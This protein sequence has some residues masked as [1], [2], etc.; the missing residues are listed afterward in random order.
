MTSISSRRRSRPAP[1]P[2]NRLLSVAG[3]AAAAIALSLPEAPL[4]AA[5]GGVIG[6]ITAFPAGAP[7]PEPPPRQMTQGEFDLLWGQV[8]YAM[9]TCSSAVE[10]AQLGWRAKGDVP[11][12]SAVRTAGDRCAEASVEVGEVTLPISARGEVR[13]LLRQAREACE[14]SM[15]EKRMS[16]AAVRRLADSPPYSLEAYEARLRIEAV[17][18][19]SITCGATFAAAAQAAGLQMAEMELAAG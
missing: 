17:D 10:A 7:F 13:T 18:R 16:L 6:P 15:I 2:R 14:R 5:S 3:L 9:A 12:E 19:G 1:R 8:R 11:S 4:T